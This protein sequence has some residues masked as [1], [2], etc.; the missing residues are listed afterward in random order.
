[1]DLGHQSNLGSL[2]SAVLV[3]LLALASNQYLRMDRAAIKSFLDGLQTPA[4]VQPAEPVDPMA[5]A[6]RE[7]AATI[8]KRESE[9]ST[10][11]EQWKQGRIQANDPR[12]KKVWKSIHDLRNRIGN[13]EQLWE[14][15]PTRAR[16]DWI[17]ILFRAAEM[18]PREF[19]A[20]FLSQSGEM[21]DQN[22][23]TVGVQAAVLRIYH[24]FDRRDPNE[25]ELCEKL[26]A[27]AQANPD[28]MV[29]IFLYLIISRDLYEA[30]HRDMSE[31]VLRRG[32][33]V[34]SGFPGN[35]GRIKLINELMDQ[36][37]G[38]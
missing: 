20:A 30:G 38:K 9:L 10:V 13:H 21:V 28:E 25:A 18:N 6:T 34:Y 33:R 23:Q 29:G 2:V 31:R 8:E 16:V 36:Q 15:L 19:S 26:Q 17:W 24:G 14:H 5:V 1:M 32:I 35:V 11:F 7:V 3:G 4:A 37:M 22:D 27:F 12:L